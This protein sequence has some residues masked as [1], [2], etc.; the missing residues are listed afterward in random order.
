MTT[1]QTYQPSSLVAELLRVARR[2]LDVATDDSYWRGRA[3]M[4][5][6]MI[7]LAIITETRSEVECGTDFDEWY[8]AQMRLS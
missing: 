3:S 2:D 5:R 8:D 7:G 6:M 4:A 1:M